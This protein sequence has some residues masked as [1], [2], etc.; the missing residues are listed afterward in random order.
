MKLMV[1]LAGIIEAPVDEVWPLIQR[2]VPFTEQTGTT[3]AHQGGWWYR[4]EWSAQSHGDHTLVTHRVY[5]V[6]QTM[7]WGVPLANRLFI[8]FAR[9]TRDRFQQRITDMARHLD[10]TGHLIDTPDAPN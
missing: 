8:G 6:A 1:D 3:G 7:R 4:G 10:T 5:N 9:N 2:A